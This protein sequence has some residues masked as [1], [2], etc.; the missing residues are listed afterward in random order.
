MANKFEKWKLIGITLISLLAILLTS[1]F[2]I[3]LFNYV[4]VRKFNN[5]VYP[6]SYLGD[7]KISDVGFTYLNQRIE[8]FSDSILNNTITLNVNGSEYKYTFKELN[9]EIDKE[10]IIAEIKKE[11]EEISY[12][13]KLARARGKKKQIYKY[14]LKYSRNYLTRIVTEI[15]NEVDV[16]VVYDDLVMSADR[17]LSYVPGVEGYNLDVEKSVNEIVAAIEQRAIG[18]LSIELVGEVTE[19]SKNKDLAVIDTMVSSFSTEFNQYIT[20]ATNLRTGLAYIDGVIIQ[21]GEIFSFYD[22]AGPY[23]K[24][25]YVFYHEFVGNGVCQVATTVYNAALLGGLE[26]VKRYPHKAKSVYVP[27]GLDATVASYS[28]G[29]NVDMQF[30][31]TYDYPI[32]ISAYAIGGT[33][34]VDFWSNH[35]AKKGK[36]YSTSSVQIAE[37]G[38]ISY[39]HIYENGEE[40]DKRKIDTTWY[41]E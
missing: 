23:D 13:N 7:Y 9:L 11:Q 27:G 38:Y 20:R 31:N 10:A 18:D 4:K 33:A 21:P 35:D 19:A 14:K 6:N 29:W 17:Q 1:I 32:Y 3:F 26:I 22:Y 2:G 15:K 12:A 36:T 34:H 40:I 24:K 41:S 39:L 5:V 16:N 8:F 28:S 30:K 25:G 37:R